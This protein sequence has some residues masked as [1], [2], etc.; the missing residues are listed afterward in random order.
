MGE[1][2]VKQAQDREELQRFT[3]KLL[4]DLRALERM[5]AEELIESDIGRIGAEQELFLV[6]QHWRPALR[7]MELLEAID[8]PHF[9][10]ELGRFNVEFNLDPIRLAGDC[11]RQL[12]RQLTD[13]L[14]RAREAGEPLGIRPLMTGILP[15]LEKSHLTLDGMTPMPRYYALNEAM[16]RLRGGVY[17]LRIKGRDELIVE[18]DNVMLEACNTSFQ[19]HFQVPQNEFARRYN[20]A[21]AVAA[22]TLAC[23]VNSPLLF[24]RQLWLETRIALFQQSIDT[25]QPSETLR[26]Q[27]PR[28]SF[29]RDWVRE[30]VLEIFHEDIARFR[31][32]MAREVDEDPFEV[33]DRGEIP[34]LPALKLHNG[35][36]YRWNRPCYGISDGKP[37]LRIENRVLPAGPSARDELA[38]AAF[39]FGLMEGVSQEYGD[40][41]S[42]MAFSAAHDNFVR[43]ARVGLGANLDWPGR[44]PTPG[45]VLIRE[46]LLPL[47]RQGLAELGIDA[48]DAELYLD[49]IDRRTASSR[50]GAGWQ[51]DSL[52]RMGDQGSLSERLAALTAGLASRQ[53]G[54]EPAHEWT[55]ARLE[56]AG[57]SHRHHLR[58]EQLMTTDLFTVGED[59][60]VDLAAHVMHW[61]H[62]RHVPVEDEQH[63][64]VGLVTY[65]ALLK[66]LV[67]KLGRGS[68][69][70]ETPVRE[71]M[72]TNLV[73][74]RPETPSLTAL[75]LMRQHRISCLPVVTDDNRLAGIITERDFIGVARDL[76]EHFLEGE[77]EES[78]GPA[79]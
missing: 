73:T 18:H 13:L 29:G 4:L 43:A 47:A 72:Q 30:S 61:R 2:E 51:L 69:S 7:S 34:D 49:V 57:R 31:V 25:R 60:L 5:L 37:H 27:L 68:Q 76:L 59:E 26:E 33:L 77:T 6:D 71:I 54:S 36:I 40:I 15:T 42:R 20:I 19:L 23:A 74:V 3:R 50:T 32:L 35:T 9:T 48:S 78:A 1:H 8:D 52:Q 65:R 56:E 58:V 11:L 46:T 39:W 21:Q 38:N 63:R 64:L 45:P 44:G 28:V 79:E 41:S 12:E 24:G 70:V 62:I 53:A 16:N 75:G 10:T 55:P 67:E 17:Q 66:L 14:A 22:P